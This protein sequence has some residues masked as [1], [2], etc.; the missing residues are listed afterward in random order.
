MLGCGKRSWVNRM[1]KTSHLRTV[2]CSQARVHLELL[3]DLVKN[4]RVEG[5]WMD[6]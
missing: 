2:G 3:S 6:E 4:A 5:G 1:S